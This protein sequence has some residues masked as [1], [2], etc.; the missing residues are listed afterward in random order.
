VAIVNQAF[1][2]RV[3]PGPAPSMRRAILRADP[4]LSTV[5]VMTLEEMASR[6][7]LPQRLAVW[8]GGGLG[9][10]ALFLSAVGVYGGL[11][12]AVAQRTRGRRLVT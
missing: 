12:F 11:A 10:L 8:L 1:A 5:P 6:N 2:R 3:W 7:T 9:V 4:N